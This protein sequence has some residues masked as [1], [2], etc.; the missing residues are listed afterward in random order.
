MITTR[1]IGTGSALPVH[2]LTNDDLSKFLDTSDEW[3]RTRTGICT[4]QLAGDGESTV[5]L[6][7]EA[8]K[9]ALL[10]SGVSPEE[11]QMVLV[12]TCSSEN[13]F[14]SVGCRVQEA[15]GLTHAS[16]MDLSAA[17][18][19]FLFALHTAHAYIVSGYCRTVLVIGAETLSRTI[20]WSD[21]STCVLFGDGAGA[22]VV[23]GEE[24]GLIQILQHSDGTKGDVLMAN[25]RRTAT[26]VSSEREGMPLSMDGQAVFRFA[27]KTVPECIQELMAK[28]DRSL[29]EV[30]HVVLHQANSRIIESV[31]KRL[32]MPLEKFAINL[33]R[34]GN[35]SAASIP[36]LLDEMNREGRLKKGDLVLLSG[37]GAG[38]TWGAALLEW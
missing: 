7:V 27:V 22:C 2:T 1:I 15:L 9:K 21:R 5:T 32:H 20:D 3:I 38:L 17:C 23:R 4:R 37:F 29:E 11:I 30:D 35:T 12:A 6:A 8:G 25:T 36:L 18:S 19:G 31:A 34:H 13:Y 28:T 14:P 16:A 26:P 10:N 24:T 33:D